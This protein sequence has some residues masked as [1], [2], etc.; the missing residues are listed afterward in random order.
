M[1]FCVIVDF[2]YIWFESPPKR[3]VSW[4]LWYGID[5][6]EMRI[7]IIFLGLTTGHAKDTEKKYILMIERMEI[8]K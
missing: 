8:W 4:Q 3:C 5:G 7:F 6:F 2:G 1:G